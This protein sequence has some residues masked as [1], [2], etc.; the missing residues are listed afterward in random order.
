MPGRFEGSQPGFDNLWKLRKATTT[1]SNDELVEIAKIALD[2][3]WDYRRGIDARIEKLR[4]FV[5]NNETVQPMPGT[6]TPL[7][8]GRRPN[9][10]KTA[11]VTGAIDAVDKPA[12]RRRTMSKAGRE[13][14]AAAQKKRWAKVQKAKKQSAASVA[15]YMR[16]Y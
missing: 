1:M 13:R 8:R 9:K 11:S 6:V 3:L 5:N 14:I 15:E 4:S 12:K 10:P 7:K 16:G 2:G